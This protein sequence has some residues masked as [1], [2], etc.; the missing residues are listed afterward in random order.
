MTKS[1][2]RI[3]CFSEENVFTVTSEGFQN[4]DGDVYTA[5]ELVATFGYTKHF[6]LPTEST[7]D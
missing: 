7:G 5:E 4:L 3:V 2:R 1:P 6:D